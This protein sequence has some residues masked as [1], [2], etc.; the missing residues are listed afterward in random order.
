[1][2]IEAR[3]EKALI[4]YLA[5]QGIAA[6][7][8][9]FSETDPGDNGEGGCDTCG[10]GSAGMTFDIAYKIKGDDPKYGWRYKTVDGDPLNFLPTLFEYDED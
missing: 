4:R 9:R 3:I 2:S 5:D 7:V 10:W 8:A 6:I 1:M